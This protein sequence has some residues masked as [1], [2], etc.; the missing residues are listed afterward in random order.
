MLPTAK[1]RT[2]EVQNLS[3]K[4]LVYNSA[5]GDLRPHHTRMG[6]TPLETQGNVCFLHWRE[7]RNHVI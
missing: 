3:S 2:P 5:M 7:E 4:H 1:D 6:L